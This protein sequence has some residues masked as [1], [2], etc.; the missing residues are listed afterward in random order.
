MKDADTGYLRSIYLR[1]GHDDKGL[2]ASLWPVLVM[3]AGNPV[4]YGKL[5]CPHCKQGRIACPACEFFMKKG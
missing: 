3:A 2:A 4:I 1:P 5:A